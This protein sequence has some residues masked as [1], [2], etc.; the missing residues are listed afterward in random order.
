MTTNETRS[1]GRL[2][3]PGPYIAEVTNNLD[4]TYMGSME[5]I[6]QKNQA[7]P[8]DLQSR[9]FIVKWTSPFLGYTSAKY[10]GNNSSDFNDVQKSYGMWMVPPDVGTR[11]LVVF[12]LGNVS[13]GYVI[14]CLPAEFQ[15]H[16]IP[17][18]AASEQSSITAEQQRRYG[19]EL[20]PVAEIHKGSQTL[21]E[22]KNPY[23]IKKAVHPFAD[24]L[25]AQ[26]LLLDTIRGVTSSGARRETPSR[27]FGISTPGPLDP[28]GKKGKLGYEGNRQFPVSRL[29]GHT[30]VMDDGDFNGENELVRIRT[31]TGHQILLHNSH[32]LIYIANSKGT[33]WIEMTSDGKLDI[34]A[35]DSVSIHTEADFN[36]RADRDINLEAGRNFNLKAGNNIN[37][38]ADED[39]SLLVDNHGRIKC[40]GGLNQSAKES[41]K[42]TSL[43]SL[44]LKSNEDILAT[45]AASINLLSE[46]GNNFTTNGDTNISSVGNMTST[47]SEIHM[48]GPTAAKASSASDAEVPTSLPTFT[49]PNISKDF[50]WSNGNFYKA[51]D[52]T[53]I[54]QRVPTHEPWPQHESI[55]KERF[56]KGNTD[57]Y[58]GTTNETT[59]NQPLPTP[60]A[61]QPSEWAKDEDFINK[62]KSVAGALG[63]DYIDLLACMSFETGRTFDPAKRNP[64]SSATGLIQ[65]M[66]STARSLG[67][68]TQFLAGLTRTQQMDWVSKYFKAGPLARVSGP[69]IEDLYMAILYPVAVGKPNDY[70][71]FRAGSAEYAVNPLDKEGKGYV[72]KADAAVKVK[73]HLSYVRQEIANYEARKAQKT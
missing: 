47:A 40:G 72:T 42:F 52:I 13:D 37:I 65:F 64:K 39:F 23:F 11:V 12:V 17:G 46:S 2:P 67:T 15:N 32:D 31:R 43:A 56:S 29:G 62:V 27:V 16:M 1:P 33:A 59:S 57:S 50:G 34:Y 73:Q 71:L 20:L 6:L 49:L 8:S 28:D 63:C 36:F 35:Q 38:N 7:I 10:E 9:T 68:T 30:F 21:N 70:V 54:M 22:V 3:H 24:R 53:S 44:H 60:N 18:I 14:A 48:N 25:L 61:G 69:K 26:G 51:D 45:S 58:A 5:V 55:N 19:T 41:I 66:A 4:P